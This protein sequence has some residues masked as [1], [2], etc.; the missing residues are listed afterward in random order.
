[1]TVGKFR[2]VSP[3]FITFPSCCSLQVLS[4]FLYKM[5]Q[6]QVSFV[7]GGFPTELFLKPV[8]NIFICPL[9]M[10]VLK[11]PHQCKNGHLFCHGCALQ[12]F[13]KRST[14]PMC[15]CCFTQSRMSRSLFVRDLVQDLSVHCSKIAETGCIWTGKLGDLPTHLHSGSCIT[16]CDTESCSGKMPS[17]N[18][19]GGELICSETLS[20]PSLRNWF[21]RTCSSLKEEQH[22]EVEATEEENELNLGF[23]E[24]DGQHVPGC[25]C[26]NCELFSPISAYSHQ[27]GES[28]SD[29]VAVESALEVQEAARITGQV[30]ENIT[31][32][33]KFCGD[34]S[35]FKQMVSGRLRQLRNSPRL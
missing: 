29:I 21:W 20:T 3:S 32:W 35:S 17:R 13:S 28:S 8:D 18:I 22:V 24:D 26:A 4:I 19:S 30:G 27:A 7:C 16:C 34:V 10:D 33:G 15:A 25:V 11:D 2:L 1:M 12:H 23:L 31:R 5:S 6:N 9:C 14:C